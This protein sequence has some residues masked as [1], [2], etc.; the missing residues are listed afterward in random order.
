MRMSFFLFAKSKIENYWRRTVFLLGIYFWEL[1]NHKICQ[2]KFGKLLE[3]LLVVFF[4]NIPKTALSFVV[5][6]SKL[7]LFV[8]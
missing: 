7:A 4:K 5:D 8:E 6:G 3:M 2:I 1:A